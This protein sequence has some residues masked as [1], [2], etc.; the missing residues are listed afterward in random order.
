[1]FLPSMKKWSASRL[2]RRSALGLLHLD[3][4]QY[5][6]VGE[7]VVGGGEGG[8]GYLQSFVG[9]VEY[10]GQRFLRKLSYR[11]GQLMAVFLAY[12][13]DL[14]EYHRV[15]VFAERC[16]ASVAYGERRLGHYLGAVDD[17]DLSEAFAERT[18]ALRG[19]EREVVG[20]RLAVG[21]AADR[22]HQR[23]AQMA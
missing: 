21:D 7:E 6:F 18:R 14:P 1:M 23:L 15:A 10:V 12:C 19:V 11:S 17:I 8:V 13:L 20:R 3:V 2:R 16:D 5:A 9:A 4:F 22:I